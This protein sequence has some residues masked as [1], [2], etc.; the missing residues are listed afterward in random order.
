[1]RTPD[2]AVGRYL[3][4]FTFLPLPKIE[5]IMERQNQDPSKRVAQHALAREF[6]ELIHGKNEADLVSRQHRQLFGSGDKSDGEQIAANPDTGPPADYK[7][8]FREFANR[9]AG[10]K[11]APPVGFSNIGSLHVT[12]P[13]SLVFNRAFGKVLYSAG[14]VNSR[15]ESHRLIMNGGA[16]VGGASEGTHRPELRDEVK[17]VPIREGWDKE[18]TNEFVV[19]DEFMLL[20][21]GKWKHKIVKI[22]SDDEFKN[23]GLDAPG[24]NSGMIDDVPRMEGQK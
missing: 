17:Y 4:L 15:S 11:F 7:S 12:L 19:D 18:K 5:K 23:L 22:I 9:A 1:V 2:D 16:H 6:V 24:W 20:R 13:R 8:S 3:K 10:N 14:M 21:V